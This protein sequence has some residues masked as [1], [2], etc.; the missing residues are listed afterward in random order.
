MRLLQGIDPLLEVNVV[1]G[2]LGLFGGIWL[3]C[4]PRTTV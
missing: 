3:A 1:G 4:D 2:Q